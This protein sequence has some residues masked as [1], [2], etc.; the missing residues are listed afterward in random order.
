M[1]SSEFIDTVTYNVFRC[2][3]RKSG[4]G[5]TLIAVNSFFKSTQID[6]THILASIPTIDVVAVSLQKK[7]LTLLLYIYLRVLMLIQLSTF[8]I[9]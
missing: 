5:G 1:H 2:D 9:Y 8:L 6:L 7:L 4:G 3:T